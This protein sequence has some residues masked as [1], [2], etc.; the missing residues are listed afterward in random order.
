MKALPPSRLPLAFGMAI[1]EADQETR[2]IMRSTIP[3]VPWFVFS[4]LGPGAYQR[5]AKRVYGT[6]APAPYGSR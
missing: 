2:D 6:S 1:Y 5:Y 3:A 4:L